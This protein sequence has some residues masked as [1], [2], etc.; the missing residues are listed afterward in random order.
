MRIEYVAPQP[1]RDAIEALGRTED[2][3][4]SPDNRRLAV[5]G[6]AR[7]RIAV[8]EVA[9][10]SSPTGAQVSVTGVLELS[11][12]ALRKPHGLE[13]I[14]DETLIVANRAGD[15]VV[16]TLP[17]GEPGVRSLAAMPLQTWRAGELTLIESPGSVVLASSEPD[18]HEVLVCNNHIHTVTRH[19]FDPEAEHILVG[20]KVVLRKWLNVPDGVAVSHDRRWIAIS[21]H[22]THSVLVYEAPPSLSAD[23]DPVA[24]LHGLRYPHGLRFSGDDR[25]LFVAD[26]GAPNVHIYTRNGDRWRGVH[27]PESTIQVVE[28]TV[29]ARGHVNPQEGGPKGLD[30]TADGGVLVTTTEFQS[31]AFFDIAAALEAAAGR[32][33]RATGAAEAGNPPLGSQEAED[34]PDV[35]TQLRLMELEARAEVAEAALSDVTAGM[36]WRITAPLRRLRAMLQPSHDPR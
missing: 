29:F 18:R 20:S 12:P 15:V 7:D 27:R 5:A 8:L 10:E 4:L 31:L 2:L 11:S 36:S 1:V 26:A 16:F 23:S 35:V 32:D 21:N 19:Q 6:F 22:N 33:A 14:D 3:R 28:D 30:I 34:V 24:V 17:R 9:F 25:R 13:F